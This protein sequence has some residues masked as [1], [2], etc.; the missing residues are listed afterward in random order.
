MAR[1]TKLYSSLIE[2]VG[3]GQGYNIGVLPPQ[4]EPPQHSSFARQVFGPSTRWNM[5]SA[6]LCGVVM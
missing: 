3:L 6:T 4:G 5:A 2:R 1:A